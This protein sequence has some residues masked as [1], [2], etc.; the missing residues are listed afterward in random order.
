MKKLIIVLLSMS[1]GLTAMAATTD[2]GQDANRKASAPAKTA[3][4][5]QLVLKTVTPVYPRELIRAAVEGYVKLSVTVDERG[6][7]TGV[8]VLKADQEAFAEAAVDALRKW[9]FVE[10]DRSAQ[11]KERHVEVP[12]RF[13][14]AAN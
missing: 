8:K 3:S 4:L 14:L 12:I 13:M 7:V 5:D 2:S 9:Q 10:A 1:V 6:N 11:K